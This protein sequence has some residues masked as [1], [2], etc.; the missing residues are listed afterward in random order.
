MKSIKSS[1]LLG[2]LVAA[3]GA[4]AAEA[5]TNSNVQN[6]SASNRAP[7]ISFTHVGARYMFQ[8]LD[9]D[10]ANCDQD[11]PNIYGSLDIQ[12]GW[13]ARASFADVG[14]DHGCGSRNV[15]VGGGFHTQLDRNL[16]AYGSLS[17]ETISP[18]H[19][20]SD[21]GLIFAAGIR[22]FLTKEL[23]GG[24]ELQHSTT[25]DG[26]TSI[27]GLLAYWFNDMIAATVDVGLGSDITT[28]AIGA[29]LNF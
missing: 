19:W 8:D 23:E 2:S 12:D 20:K 3:L 28:F 5:Q 16:T 9:Q 24:L 11:G 4:S 29:R 10:D 27:N 15:Q 13:Y 22:G 26:N 21:S 6:Y 25:F 1:L 7:V 14:G 17:F 18:D